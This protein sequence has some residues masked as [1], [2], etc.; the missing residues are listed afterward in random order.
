MRLTKALKMDTEIL[1]IKN[2]IEIILKSLGE[3]DRDE[4][5]YYVDE[6]IQREG[7]ILK[8]DEEEHHLDSDKIIVF[9]DEEPGKNWGHNCR[10]MLFNIYTRRVNT[11]RAR[12]PPNLIRGKTTYKLFYKPDRVEKWALWD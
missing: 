3:R 11:I 7:T 4:H 12:F 2:V 8:I 5:V 9:V 1:T 10:F 6:S